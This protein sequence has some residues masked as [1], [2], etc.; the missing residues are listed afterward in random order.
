MG[1]VGG[2]DDGDDGEFVLAVRASDGCR[3][4]DRDARNRRVRNDV[5]NNV[6][7]EPFDNAAAANGDRPQRRCA[8][9]VA[10]RQQR[11]VG[12]RKPNSDGGAKHR[13][14][15][16]DTRNAEVRTDSPLSRWW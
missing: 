2:D 14:P 1:G 3:G 16:S 5:V 10:R 4:A 11:G 13:H 12:V 8:D 6:G 9:P 15:I 7:D